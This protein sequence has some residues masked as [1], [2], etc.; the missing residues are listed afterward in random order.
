MGTFHLLFAQL[1]YGFSILV[2]AERALKTKHVLGGQRPSLTDSSVERSE[3]LTVEDPTIT[4]RFLALEPGVSYRSAHAF[5]HEQL[6]R[7]KR[8]AR[9]VLHQLTTENRENKAWQSAAIGW[10]NLNQMALR[11]FLMLLRVTSVGF[12]SSI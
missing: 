8:C 12:P 6:G 3:A 2:M 9:R 7:A 5:V 4:L 11:G 1:P 10:N